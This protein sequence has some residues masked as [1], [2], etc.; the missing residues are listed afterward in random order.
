MTSLILYPK[1]KC[2]LTMH[3]M[4]PPA[5]GHNV[6]TM[7]MEPG[8]SNHIPKPS[9]K[10]MEPR[11]TV[12]IKYLFWGQELSGT[13]IRIRVRYGNNVEKH[14]NQTQWWE[15]TVESG[16]YICPG[17]INRWTKALTYTIRDVVDEQGPKPS[18]HKD[19]RKVT[20]SNW[21]YLK[22][23]QYRLVLEGLCGYWAMCLY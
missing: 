3:L 12:R 6:D 19:S 18:D 9:H 7:G 16:F 10:C 22:A 14:C 17:V 2:L 5:G 1:R 8:S 23:Y 11:G 15:W 13:H 4:W 20:C 21:A